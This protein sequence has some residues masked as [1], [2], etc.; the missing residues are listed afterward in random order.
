MRIGLLLLLALVGV[1]ASILSSCGG[2]N[3]QTPPKPISTD[4]QLTVSFSGSGSGD[5]ASTPAGISCKTGNS[6]GCSVSL[7]SGTAVKLIVTPDQSAVFGGWQGG[8]CTGT[9]SS[10]TFTLTANTNVVVSM[11]QGSTQPP[12]SVQLTVAFAGNGTGAVVSTPEG[13]SCHTG[14]NSGCSASFP[15]GTSIK[16]VATPDSST[17]VGGWQGSGCSGSNP[18]CTFALTANSNVVLTLNQAPAP[19][20]ANAQITVIES[21]GGQGTVVSSPA[22]I[23]CPGTCSASFAAS[24]QVTLTATS[25]NG[26][27]F[28]GYSGACTNIGGEAKDARKNAKGKAAISPTCTF[29]ANGNES[30]T[31]LFTT[32][33]GPPPPPPTSSLS[34]RLTGKGSVTSSPAGIN[35]PTT[36]DASF[37]Q[38]TVVTL[39]ETDSVTAWHFYQWTG[40]CTG[41]SPTCQVT[42]ASTDQAV[43]AV[44]NTR[45]LLYRGGP[46]MP[47]T[48]TKAIFWGVKWGDSS[49]VADKIDG[50]DSWYEGVGGSNYAGS[51][52]EYTDSLGQEVSATS[53]YTGHVV[54]TT[55]ASDSGALEEACKVVP[56]PSADEYVAVYL[57][58]PRPGD[59]CAYHTYTSCG[60][61]TNSSHIAVAVFYNLD[62]DAGCSPNDTETGHSQGLAAIANMSG[63]EFS[64]ARSDPQ[65]TSWLDSNGE[66]T[67]DLCDFWFADPYVTFSNGTKWKIQANWSNYANDN[68]LGQVNGGCVDFNITG[69]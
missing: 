44:F 33:Q 34:V 10:C 5:V 38:G 7:A 43:S 52:D 3:G 55:T 56:N 23:N 2:S 67:S 27:T 1:S 41:T 25:A 61:T 59:W 14:S 35:C 50:I 57:D 6:T 8:G 64:E 29:V 37:P 26:S 32:T 60:G 39:T 48:T 17:L 18:T 19:P 54:D 46:I 68:G 20:P 16:L 22:G 42:I 28:G 12:T 65:L 40:A 15:S 63:H 62:N 53:T 45:D 24:T 49:F 4:F 11:N 13:I 9:A 21:G 51:I 47:T 66:E 36:C 58:Q 30:V 69:K 31:A